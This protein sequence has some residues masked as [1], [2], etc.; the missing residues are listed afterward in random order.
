MAV[1]YKMI[2][3]SI[4]PNY[5]YFVVFRAERVVR[6]SSE[7]RLRTKNKRPFLMANVVKSQRPQFSLTQSIKAVARSSDPQ[8]N[9]FCTYVEQQN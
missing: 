5:P 3:S 9:A 7:G 6:M 1:R 8:Q 2:S 4:S